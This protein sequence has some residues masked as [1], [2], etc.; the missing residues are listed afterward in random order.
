MRLRRRSSCR[1]KCQLL[2]CDTG[3]S[4]SS[5]WQRLQLEVPL[6]HCSCGLR[7]LQHRLGHQRNRPAM[8]KWLVS[9]PCGGAGISDGRV[10]KEPAGPAAVLPL[11]AF[12]QRPAMR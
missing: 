2:R 9:R 12:R 11:A 8:A 3:I 7:Q 6:A 5:S 4:K 10:T 1:L